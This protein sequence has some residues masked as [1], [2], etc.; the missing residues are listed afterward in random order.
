ME[1]RC[2]GGHTVC[3]KAQELLD[4]HD[5]MLQGKRVHNQMGQVSSLQAGDGERER[6]KENFFVPL[7]LY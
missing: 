6:E 5:H 4:L 3:S 1:L 7:G 2:I